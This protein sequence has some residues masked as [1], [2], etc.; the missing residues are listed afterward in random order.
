M[1]LDVRAT[2]AQVARRRAMRL[3]GSPVLCTHVI[4][5]AL[6]H[7]PKRLR[8]GLTGRPE[9]RHRGPDFGKRVPPGRLIHDSALLLLHQSHFWKRGFFLSGSKVG[10]TRSHPG[11]R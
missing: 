9:G 7:F 11:V 3:L 4:A 6:L 10:S 8:R 1:T 5:D 2:P